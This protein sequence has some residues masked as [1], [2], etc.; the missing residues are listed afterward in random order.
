MKKIFLLSVLCPLLLGA[1]LTSNSLSANNVIRV[2]DES[3]EVYADRLEGVETKVL[4]G[5]SL[6]VGDQELSYSNVLTQYGVN[7]TSGNDY[8]RFIT[9]VKGNLSSVS[10]DLSYND[11]VD[12]VEVVVEKEVSISTLYKGITADGVVQYYGENGLTTNEA[13]ST[14]YFAC[15]TLEFKSEAKLETIF[16]TNVVVEDSEGVKTSGLSKATTLQELKY[17]VPSD[18]NVLVVGADIL[19]DYCVDTLLPRLCLAEDNLT[20]NYYE[21]LS[22]TYSIKTLSDP[23][24]NYGVKFR[25]ALAA[26]QYDAIVVQISRRVTESATDV[27]A[28]ELQALKDVYPLLQQETSNIKLMSYSSEATPAT[29]YVN[30]NGDYAKTG[31]KE[32]NWDTKKVGGIWY[33]ALADTWA[34]EI[35]ALDSS[36]NLKSLKYSLVY[37][38]SSGPKDATV[39][40]M[41]G[42]SLYMSLFGK[43]YENTSILNEVPQK[44]SDKVSTMT[45]DAAKKIRGWAE[46]H[47]LPQ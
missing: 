42:A 5:K 14:Y 38:E 44:D 27:I 40:Y 26:A 21:C 15:Y 46:K 36:Y 41:I 22:G 31:N 37:N 12:E 18:Y 13:E 35:N 6:V 30:E 32:T 4:S 9:A 20:V 7:S 39:G 28:A 11:V 24:H 25:K 17:D 29:F 19:G 45:V 2:E 23:N 33:A 47:I 8:I 43:T 1:A 34:N 16:N 3:I 10:F